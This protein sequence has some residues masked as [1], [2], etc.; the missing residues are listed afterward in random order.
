MGLILKKFNNCFKE[1]R[2]RKESHLRVDKLKKIVTALLLVILVISAFAALAAPHAKA[3]TTQATILSYSWYTSQVTTQTLATYYGDLVVVGEVENTGTTP[4]STVSIHGD[5]YNSSGLVYLGYADLIGV[6]ELL[7]GQKAPF[8]M[9]FYPEESPCDTQAWVSSVTSV[10]LQLGA[11]VSTNQ[12]QY[13]GLTIPTD[14]LSSYTSS[15]AY[16]VTGSIENDGDQTVGHVWVLVTYYNSSGTVIGMNCTNYLDPS[17]S[18]SP[19]NAVAFT[20]IPSDNTAQ[21]SSQIANYALLVES[22]PTRAAPTPRR[23]EAKHTNTYPFIFH[24]ASN[25]DSNK[26]TMDLRRSH[27][28]QRLLLLSSSP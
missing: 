12:T 28:S 3:Q 8:Y 4:L 9:D 19:G 2:V 13:S 5:A 21:M 24:I 7:P 6:P 10:T 26:L 14:S 1:M 25:I 16:T 18:L 20:A 11:V 23:L 15:G 22:D 17:G 27:R